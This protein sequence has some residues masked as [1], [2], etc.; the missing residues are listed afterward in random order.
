MISCALV[1]ETGELA[2]DRKYIATR[3]RRSCRR[4]LND[5]SCGSQDL[6][7]D[8]PAPP[9]HIRAE[10]STIFSDRVA[11]RTTTVIQHDRRHRVTILALGGFVPFDL[12]IPHGMFAQAML[13]DG[14]TPYEVCFAAPSPCVCS[15]HVTISGCQPL[16]SLLQ[17]DTVIVPG[18]VSPRSH[19]DEA[20]SAILREAVSCGARVASICTGAWVLAASGILDGL[21]ATTHWEMTAGLAEAYP[22]IRIEHEALFV[23][24]GQILTSAG[25]ASGI[26]LCLHMIRTD[27]GAAVAEACARFFVVPVERE[28]RQTQLVRHYPPQSDDNLATLQLWLLENLHSD[29]S[30]QDIAGHACVSQRTLNRRFHEQIGM[31]P[32]AWLTK[33]RMR[34]AQS[35]LEVSSMSVEQVASA[36][37]FASAAAFRECFRRFVGTS[38]TAWRKTYGDKA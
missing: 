6:L 23:D 20:V 13:Q 2:I 35:L 37:G 12:S 5:L 28:G 34:R 19:D 17:A 36:T 31:T 38:P 22:S 3:V 25:L 26:D 7:H 14:S 30:L 18:I 15:G 9:L 4:P 29:L 32:M 33:A 27:F 24:N 11:K 16:E 1:V 21:S 8:A 10:R